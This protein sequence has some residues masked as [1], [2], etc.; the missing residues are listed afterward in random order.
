MYESL[1]EKTHRLLKESE[2]SIPN[3]HAELRMSGITSISYY[4]LRKFSSGQI[5]DPSVNKVQMLYEFLSGLPL[6]V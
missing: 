6:N 4:W 1:M 5:K 3:V 2:L